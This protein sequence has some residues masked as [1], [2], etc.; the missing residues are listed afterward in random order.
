MDLVVKNPLANARD[1]RDAVQSFSP[2]V[3]KIPWRRTWLPTVVFLPV[4]SHGQ[5]S[6]AGYSHE[7]AKSQILLSFW[8]NSSFKDQFW[9]VV[10]LG[11]LRSILDKMN[12]CHLNI[13]QSII[14]A[15]KIKIICLFFL[16]THLIVSFYQMQWETMLRTLR[17]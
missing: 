9:C 11:F 7:A 6:L 10:L 15:Q 16:T 17:T 12:C 3:G 4:E 14:F 2:L 1:I 13:V 5:R 8:A